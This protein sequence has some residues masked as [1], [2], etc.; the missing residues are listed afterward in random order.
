[1]FDGFLSSNGRLLRFELPRNDNMM[2]NVREHRLHPQRPV[3]TCQR[4]P[5]HRGHLRRTRQPVPVEHPARE[6][7]PRHRGT[8]QPQTA[9]RR[10]CRRQCRGTSR[11]PHEHR[12]RG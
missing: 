2:H 12:L 9:L 8:L 4:P 3:R 1:M 5:R 11:Q 6:R 10:R 7:L